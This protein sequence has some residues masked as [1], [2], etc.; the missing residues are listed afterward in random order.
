[1]LKGLGIFPILRS[2]K[3]QSRCN[4]AQSVLHARLSVQNRYWVTLPIPYLSYVFEAVFSLTEKERTC[5]IL[6]RIKY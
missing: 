4:L 5:D 1:M 3:T 2:K 6:E